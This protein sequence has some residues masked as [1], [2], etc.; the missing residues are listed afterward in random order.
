M[1][2]RDRDIFRVLRRCSTS[3]SPSP[4]L[5]IAIINTLVA[6]IIYAERSCE[7]KSGVKSKLQ[8]FSQA[9]NSVT[10]HFVRHPVVIVFFSPPYFSSSFN[11][12]TCV[13]IALKL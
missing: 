10:L 7:D 8:I 2:P 9:F 5:P 3:Q 11:R 4:L 12:A 6:F 13:L 1:Y